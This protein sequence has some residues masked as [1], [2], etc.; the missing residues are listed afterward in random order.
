M[1]RYTYECTNCGKIFDLDLSLKN[2]VKQTVCEKCD[3]DAVQI[4]VPGHGGV[5][6]DHPAW[7]DDSVRGCLQDPAERPIESRTEYKRHLKDNGIV[8]RA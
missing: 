3:G 2:H 8:E 4:M 5:Q 6:D 7:I 1:P